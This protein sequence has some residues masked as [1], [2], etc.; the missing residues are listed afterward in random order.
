[1]DNPPIPEDR[2]LEAIEACR[3]GSDDLA[4]PALAHLAEKLEATAE[5][6][7]LYERIQRV[8]AGLA[9]AFHDVAVPEGLAQR[10]TDRLA[11][12]HRRVAKEP[13]PNP[14]PGEVALPANEETSQKPAPPP[15]AAMPAQPRPLSR[16]WLLAAGGLVTVAAGLFVA[17]WIVGGSQECDEPIV[18][19]EAMDR[20]RDE[21]ERAESLAAVQGHLLSDPHHPPPSAYPISRD[22]LRVRGIRWRPISGFLGRSGVAYDLPG[23]DGTTQA[24][25]YVVE[26]TVPDLGALPPAAPRRNTGGYSAAAWQAGQ[27]LYVL[28]VRGGK[29][30]YGSCLIPP[31]PL[32]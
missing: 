17:V 21:I 14:R 18:L 28:A 32:T 12:S 31:G 3:P 10:I 27:L 15:A 7:G 11:T 4:D 8:D 24:T 2:I 9:A 25:L 16:R 1:M 23:P 30:A 29:G 5:L 22:V 20:F 6:K 26:L 19:R 13:P